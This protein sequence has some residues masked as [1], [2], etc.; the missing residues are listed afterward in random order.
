MSHGVQ[1]GTL[2]T[3][4][5]DDR[6]KILKKL[7]KI[8]SDIKFDFYGIEK[9]QPI[10]GNDF[11][12]QL[13]KS[14]MAL[15]LSRGK[16]IKYYSSDRLAQLM[17]NGLLTFIDAK[18]KYSDFFDNNELITYSDFSDLNEKINRYKKNDKQRK[19]IARNG[20]LKYLRY[21]NSN[22]VAQFII[23]KTFDINKKNKYIWS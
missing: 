4:K 17:G 2:K 3:G 14:K 12:K 9:N 21:F 16:P 19:S 5:N 8:N 11:V 10:W 6:E 15:N 1:R 13:S 23:D 20:K 22:L 7:I 18:T